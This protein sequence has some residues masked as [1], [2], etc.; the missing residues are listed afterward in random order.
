M[1]FP[2]VKFSSNIILAIQL[3]YL[4]IGR[5]KTDN[6]TGREAIIIIQSAVKCQ[7]I[8]GKWC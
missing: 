7:T 8:T 1:A 4:I 3:C 6:T 5:L 2:L